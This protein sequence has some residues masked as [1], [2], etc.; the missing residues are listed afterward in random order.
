MRIR[1]GRLEGGV[2]SS[3]GDHRLAMAGAVAGL[4]AGHG[5]RVD[6]GEAVAKSYPRFFED[7][8][9]VGGDIT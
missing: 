6:G 9:S 8:A 1:G 2:V 7:L 5:V 4:R 3:R